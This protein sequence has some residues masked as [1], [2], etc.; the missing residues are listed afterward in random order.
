MEKIMPYIKIKFVQKIW[1]EGNLLWLANLGVAL[2][3]SLLCGL[4]FLIF[5]YEFFLLLSL[6]SL[7][8][9]Y[10]IYAYTGIKKGLL[11]TPFYELKTQQKKIALTFDDG[12]NPNY[13][14]EILTILAAHQVKATFFLLGQH[15]ESHPAIAQRINDEGHAIGNHSY[16]HPR[17]NLMGYK[18]LVSEIDKTQSLIKN[19][20]YNNPLLFRPPYGL[21]SP[22][23]ELILKA[24]KMKTIHWNLSSKDWKPITPT[25]ILARLLQF[26][27]PGTIV[28]LH[29]SK[30]AVAV[31]PEFIK[32]CQENGYQ[33]VRISDEL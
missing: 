19:L 2:N 27:Q 31:L 14:N 17:M 30:N 1:M 22:L 3:L 20:N 7:I 4:L 28:L 8:A 9:A 23:L 16:S 10:Y 21:K 5:Q 15:I 29:D 6:I 32:R 13:T 25:T 33:F 12:P 11:T 18:A 24:K 26:T